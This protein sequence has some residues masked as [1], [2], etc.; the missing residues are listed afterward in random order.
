MAHRGFSSIRNSLILPRR[1]ALPLNRNDAIDK[2]L[3]PMLQLLLIAPLLTPLAQDD[4]PPRPDP[5]VV[6]EAL[7]ELERAFKKGKAPERRAA[8][9]SHAGV[10]DER[11]VAW[12]AKGTK[13]KDRMVQAAALEALRWLPNEAAL[14]ALH[15]SL[16]KNRS[17]VKDD[18]LYE[19]LVKAIGQHGHPSSVEVLTDNAL[20]AAPKGVTVARIY[21]LGH[22]RSKESISALMDLMART[23]KGRKRGKGSA[24]ARMK[25][26]ATSLQVL[27]GETIGTD[28]A[29]WT[30]WWRENEGD[31]E[32]AKERPT[33]KPA[34]LEKTWRKYWGEES[35]KGKGEGRDEERER[36]KKRGGDD[37]SPADSAA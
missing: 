17:I 4:T 23:G 5:A 29:A 15:T 24:Q 32:I 33:L 27:T 6:E 16:K 14:E 8:I 19:A 2:G 31:F 34:R 12:F 25:E 30:A 1:V 35:Q 37:E 21:G 7:S 26:F 18:A 22:I 36:R 10:N 3:D 13:D 11:V 20:A 9:E 28:E